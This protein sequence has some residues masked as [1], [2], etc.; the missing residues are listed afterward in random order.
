M[1]QVA[2]GPPK[3]LKRGICIGL[4]CFDGMIRKTLAKLGAT[5]PVAQSPLGDPRPRLA[6]YNSSQPGEVTDGGD[7]GPGPSKQIEG[8]LGAGK[9]CVRC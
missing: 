8:H 3:S 4:G 1:A 5:T 6:G 7:G 2:A 9:K